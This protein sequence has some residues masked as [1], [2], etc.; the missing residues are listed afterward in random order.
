MLT[1]DVRCCLLR[2]LVDRMAPSMFGDPA[3]PTGVSIRTW[4]QS[5]VNYVHSEATP[6]PA[7]VARI[8]NFVQNGRLVGPMHLENVYVQPHSSRTFGTGSSGVFWSGTSGTDAA[9]G[10][11]KMTPNQAY[12]S[13]GVTGYFVEGLPAAGDFSPAGVAG[14][15]YGQ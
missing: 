13:S 7:S 10:R 1:S 3:I 8:I 9:T 5:R 4:V 14:I 15:S 6:A 12:P 2:I 11:Q